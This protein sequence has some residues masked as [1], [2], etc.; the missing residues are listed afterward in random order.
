MKE[1][2]P[3][4]SPSPSPSPLTDG[5]PTTP[6]YSPCFSP[7]SPIP[8]AGDVAGPSDISPLPQYDW[9]MEPV[10]FA[11]NS[12]GEVEIITADD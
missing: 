10:T 11:Y 5:A 7:V 8:E 2:S 3:I 1:S 4:R 6:H 9:R 12:K